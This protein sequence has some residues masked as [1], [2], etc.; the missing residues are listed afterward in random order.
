M[1]ATPDSTLANPEQLIA[2]LQRQLAECKAELDKAQRN[3][4]ETTT[5]RDEALAR[6]AATAEVLGAI[7]ASPGDLT[8]VFEAILEKATR[9]CDAAGILWI[10]DGTRFRAV[11]WHGVPRAFIE[12]AQQRNETE[13]IQ[14][15]SLTKIARGE[16]VVRDDDLSNNRG[17]DAVQL[18]GMRTGFLVAL[19]KGDAVLGAIRIFRRELRPFTDK[20][21]E[22][23]ENFAA[24]AVIA[25]GR[26]RP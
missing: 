15:E 13:A 5:E 6:E 17:Q 23:V 25:I 22:L 24:Q 14:T 26:T 18:A 12:R 11:A 3:L 4:N 19:R 9:L 2:D 1:S 10:Y 20:Q 7:N 21:I 8:P 16:L